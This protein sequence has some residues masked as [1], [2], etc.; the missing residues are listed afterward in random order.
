MV[1]STHWRYVPDD[2]QR[3]QSLELKPG[4][5]LKQSTPLRSD[6]EVDVWLVMFVVCTA[7][8]I[9]VF[10][11]CRPAGWLLPKQSRIIN[12]IIYYSFNKSTR[13]HKLAYPNLLKSKAILN[14]M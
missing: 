14:V 3:N 11:A 6:I 7:S 12:C 2:S 4:V 8:I 9:P 1:D 10:V 13:D 5:C